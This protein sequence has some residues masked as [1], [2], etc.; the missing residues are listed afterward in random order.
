MDGGKLKKVRELLEKL[1]DKGVKNEKPSKRK[2][3]AAPRSQKLNLEPMGDMSKEV[4]LESNRTL[5]S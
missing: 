1:K 5:G 3:K 4:L 2:E